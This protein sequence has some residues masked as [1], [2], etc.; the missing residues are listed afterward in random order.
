MFAF[1]FEG[2]LFEFAY[3]NPSFAPLFAL[4]P[5]NRPPIDR[6]NFFS[7]HSNQ[8]LFPLPR[9]VTNLGKAFRFLIS[10][11]T[12]R[13]S[14]EPVKNFSASHSGAS[15]FF[16]ILTSVCPSL[17]LALLNLVGI[18]SKKSTTQNCVLSNLLCFVVSQLK[19]RLFS[20]RGMF[21][22]ARLPSSSIPF[23]LIDFF[24]HIF[25]F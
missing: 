11:N 18:F 21:R 14:C 23:P 15:F 10:F 3:D 4:P 25:L 9:N 7:N 2:T 20:S 16:L 1:V 13:I 12:Y 17:C 19:L 22:K 6:P 24:C 5:N 8:N